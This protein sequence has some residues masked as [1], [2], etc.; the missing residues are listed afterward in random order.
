M[1]EIDPRDLVYGA[2]EE[3][4]KPLTPQ[5]AVYELCAMLW[6]MAERANMSITE[7]VTWYLTE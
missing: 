1:G 2:L 5:E 6:V 3:A 7:V 4:L